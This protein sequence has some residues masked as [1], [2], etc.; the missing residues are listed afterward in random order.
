MIQNSLKGFGRLF[1]HDLVTKVVCFGADGVATF[2]GIKTKVA[3][4]LRQTSSPFCIHVHCV[5]HKTKLAT[6]IFSNMSMVVKIE[7]L[8]TSVYTHTSVIV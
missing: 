5:V 7:A 1:D 6:L 3:T 8:L 4:Q 2:Q